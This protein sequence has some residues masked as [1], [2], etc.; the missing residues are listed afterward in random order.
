LVVVVFE[1]LLALGC[2]ATSTDTLI[3]QLR[4]PDPKARRAAARALAEPRGDVSEVVAGLSQAA[5]DAD[6]EVRELAVTTLGQIGSEAKPGLRALERALGDAS[7][8]VR[9]SAALAIYSIEPG[10]RSFQPVLIEAL[11]AGDGPVFLEVGRMGE[12]GAWAVPTLTALLSDRRP[13]IRAL[14][15]QALGGIGAAARGAE[16]ALRR[17]L[18][19]E[20]ASVRNA[21]QNALRRIGS[22]Q[23]GAS[24]A[25]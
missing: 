21:A 6:A 23:T 22:K 1:C 24:R 15:A 17:C 20:E 7:P 25:S 2:N 11:R 4:S 18:R 13:I 16:P 3:A 8:S 10:S 9:T 5:Q 12:R 19:D 14:S